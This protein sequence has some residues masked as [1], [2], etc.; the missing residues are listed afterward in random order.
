[1]FDGLHL[2]RPATCESPSR[3]LPLLPFV[4]PYTISY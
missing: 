4:R 2:K 3:S 1:M